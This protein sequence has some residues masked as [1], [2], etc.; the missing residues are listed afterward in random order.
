MSTSKAHS[1][2]KRR[3]DGEATRKRILAAALASFREHGFDATTMRD[4]AKAAGL[5]LGAAYHYFPGKEAIVLAYYV[6]LEQRF[7]A[8]IDPALAEAGSDLRTRLGVVFD[9]KFE[10][11]R[12]DRKL[13]AALFRTA[14]DPESALSPFAAESSEVRV[15]NVEHFQ[16]ALSVPA[17]PDELRR[18]LAE[19]F[20]VMHLALMLLY[21]HDR[22]PRQAR[23]A[24]VTAGLL[25]AA[26]D[27][28]PL[29]A[30]PLG[31]ALRPRLFQVLGDVATIAG[32][33]SA[34]HDDD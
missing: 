20:F 16:A 4:V 18:P 1:P 34:A 11:L 8:R 9:I 31:A 3:S 23:S 29:L 27:A 30:S 13:M 21:L 10:V 24:A 7:S 25:D 12:R 6:E 33:R 2:R 22:S 32:L 14:G 17:C 28:L 19:A 5:S 26:C 15:R